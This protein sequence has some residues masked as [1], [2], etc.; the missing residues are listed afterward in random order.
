MPDRTKLRIGDRIR[1]LAVPKCDLDQRLREIN[2]GT[3]DAGWTAD[4]IEQILRQDPVVTI[5]SIDE[6]GK[7]WFEYQLRS[8]DGEVA[9]H[10]IAIIEDDSWEFT[11]AEP[12]R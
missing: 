9:E 12:A 5:S 3:E 7:P 2:A 6:Y 10:S 11:K 1:L 4:T 8:Q